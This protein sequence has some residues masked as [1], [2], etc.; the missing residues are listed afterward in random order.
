MTIDGTDYE[1][2]TAGTLNQASAIVRL[3]DC[4]SLEALQEYERVVLAPVLWNAEL[5]RVLLLPDTSEETAAFIR[6][7][8]P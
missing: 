8:K 4:K 6:G 2:V 7:E 1:I 5:K 3:L